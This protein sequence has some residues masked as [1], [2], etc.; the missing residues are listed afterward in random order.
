MTSNQFAEE[1]EKRLIAPA[2]ALENE[3]IRM[4]LAERDDAKVIELLESEF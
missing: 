4:A 2:I 3:A 1:C